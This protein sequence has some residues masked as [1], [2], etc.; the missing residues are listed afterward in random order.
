[1]SNFDKRAL[2]KA[3]MHAKTTDDWG[4]DADNFHDKATPDAVLALLDELESVQ[5]VS[6]ARLV[7]IDT[8]HKM[9]QRERDRA[10]KAE[11]R[12]AELEAREVKLPERYEVEMCP[13]PSPDGDWYSRED[14]LAALKTAGI[15]IRGEED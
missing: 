13:T 1:M 2:R 6:A 15:N 14:V 5:T 10:E 12:I 7:A 11:R 3:A 4:C 9:F 8:T